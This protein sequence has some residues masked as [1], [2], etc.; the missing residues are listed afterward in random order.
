MANVTLTTRSRNIGYGWTNQPMQTRGGLVIRDV[1][2]PK[3]VGTPRQILA[4]VQRAARGNAGN[5]W[6]QQFFVNGQRVLM[7]DPLTG[8]SF[9]EQL[10]WLAPG[11]RVEWPLD[12]DDA[13]VLQAAGAAL[14]RE[15]EAASRAWRLANGYA[16]PE[17]LDDDL[18]DELDAAEQEHD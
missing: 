10:R 3:C 5:E 16:Y 2:E 17:D 13:P 14:A 18:D 7:V 4:E 12:D 8:T 15:A 6:R 11:I 9:L 1:D